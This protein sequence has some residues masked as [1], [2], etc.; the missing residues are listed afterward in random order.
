VPE[1]PHD[2]TVA[3]RLELGRERDRADAF[4]SALRKEVKDVVSAAVS[5]ATYDAREDLATANA[6]IKALEQ[7]VAT[8]YADVDRRELAE[9]RLFWLR[10]QKTVAM[11]KER[12]FGGVAFM[13]MVSDL[14]AQRWRKDK[15]KKQ[16]LHSKQVLE[17]LDAYEV[18]W[19]D[20]TDEG[21]SK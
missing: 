4:E 9:L 10:M 20:T 6:Q 17:K 8:L 14:V 1:V 2:A 21:Q 12:G 7:Q 16:T 13:S 19:L 15:G 5:Q 11:Q 18:S 3:L